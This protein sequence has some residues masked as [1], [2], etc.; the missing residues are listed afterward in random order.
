[1]LSNLLLVGIGVGMLLLSGIVLVMAELES[2]GIIEILRSKLTRLNPFYWNRLATHYHTQWKFSEAHIEKLR[3]GIYDLNAHTDGLVEGITV[4][5]NQIRGLT[6]KIDDLNRVVWGWQG[7]DKIR[8]GVIEDLLEQIKEKDKKF[9]ELRD[10]TGRYIDTQTRTI[11]ELNL[12]CGCASETIDHLSGVYANANSI[13]LELQEEA[14]IKDE[15]I[16]KQT[17]I[18]NDWQATDQERQQRLNHLIAEKSRNTQIIRNLGIYIEG[19]EHLID[20]LRAKIDPP[21][22]GG[23]RFVNPGKPVFHKKRKKKS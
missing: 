20:E 16:A 15:R 22:S 1:M 5:Q 17:L 2:R 19:R 10:E 12:S 18:E 11:E 6:E 13:I 8:V 4:R 23:I 7:Q 9:E 14:K 21:A 3:E